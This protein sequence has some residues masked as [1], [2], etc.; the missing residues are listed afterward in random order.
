MA[1]LTIIGNGNT[2]RDCAEVL[3]QAGFHLHHAFDLEEAV[4]TP[5]IFGEVMGLAGLVDKA[6]KQG[7]HVLIASPRSLPAARF[8]SLLAERKPD[9]ALF[10]WN[11]RRFHP[12][13][14]VLQGLVQADVTW[15]PRFLRLETMSLLPALQTLTDWQL[16]ESLSL[17]EDL[18]GA[19]PL[20]VAASMV[21]NPLRNAPDFVCLNLSLKALTAHISLSMNEPVERRDLTL[22]ADDR[23][24]YVDELNQA[25]PLRLVE[26]ER[27]AAGHARWVSCSQ[28]SSAEL[29]R[30]QCVAFLEA[31]SDAG[32]AN[33]DAVIWQRSLAMLETID[34][35]LQAGGIPVKVQT[36]Q[37]AHPSVRLLRDA[38]QQRHTQ[39]ISA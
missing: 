24:A 38:R 1:D 35:S 3:V 37:E 36:Y 28:P 30:Q 26:T 39:P 13:H 16:L 18:T 11:D 19:E 33:T 20:S 15:R 10:V 31:I 34:D 23:R 9:R 29:A 21:Y 27:S 4:E 32:K 8:A 22:V 5:V 2:T 14:R 25:V 7:R 17:I 12:A 6:L